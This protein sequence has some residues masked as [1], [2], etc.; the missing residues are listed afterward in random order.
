MVHSVDASQ[1]PQRQVWNVIHGFMLDNA[2]PR[3]GL[4]LSVS[5]GVGSRRD[6]PPESISQKMVMGDIA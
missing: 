6:T 2:V 5:D 4:S 1:L 3:E